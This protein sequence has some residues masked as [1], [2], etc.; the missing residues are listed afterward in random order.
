MGYDRKLTFFA[1]L[2]GVILVLVFASSA[3][4]FK[5]AFSLND[6]L[7]SQ[8]S[9]DREILEG[10]LIEEGYDLY[11]QRDIKELLGIY[12]SAPVELAEL[13]DDGDINWYRDIYSGDNACTHIKDGFWQSTPYEQCSLTCKT[14]NDCLDCCEKGFSDEDEVNWCSRHCRE[15][16]KKPQN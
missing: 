13:F 5:G 16:F 7:S 4:A 8:D 15:A 14:F 1:M 10:Y 9:E 3:F 2:F 12:E 6:I 11:E